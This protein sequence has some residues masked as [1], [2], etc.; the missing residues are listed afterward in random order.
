MEAEA[1]AE[2]EKPNG[3]NL[4][5]LKERARLSEIKLAA[6]LTASLCDSYWLAFRFKY[7]VVVCD[8][9]TCLPALMLLYAR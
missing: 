7:L 2:P 4:D 5:T 9:T 6:M 8:T 1:T 3:E